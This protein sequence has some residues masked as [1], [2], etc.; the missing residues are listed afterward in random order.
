MGLGGTDH[1]LPP[2]GPDAPAEEAEALDALLRRLDTVAVPDAAG[3]RIEAKMLRAA[4]AHARAALD[5]WPRHRQPSWYTGEVAFGLISLLLPSAPTG[6]ADALADRLAAIPGF[7]T[8]APAHLAGRRIPRDWSERARKE[9]AALGRFFAR[10]LPRHPLWREDWRPLLARAEAALARFAAGLFDLPDGSPGC[11]RDYLAFLM[12]E[13]HGLPW[14]PEEAVALAEDAFAR[15][16]DRLATEARRIDPSRS[17][18]E[19]LQGLSTL[20]PTLDTVPETYRRWHERTL[21]DAGDLVTPATGYGL[22][23]RLHAEWARPVIGDLYFLAYRSPPALAAGDGSVYWIP[24]P[25]ADTAAYL[26]GQ[27]TVAIKQTHAVHHGSIGHHTQNARAREAP[28][29]LARLAGTDCASGIAFLSAGTMVEGWACYATELMAEVD[30]FYTPA[31]RLALIQADRRNA[32]SVLADIR[33]HTGRWSLEEMRAFYR[34]EAGFP[35]AR[36]WGETTRNSLLPGTRLMY[37]LGTEQIKALRREVG[38]A[39]KPLFDALLGHG[40][41]PVAW[42]AEEI[43]RSRAQAGDRLSR[44]TTSAA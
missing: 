2:S 17:W 44:R 32:A 29:R 19:Q 30:G 9:V 43:R 41:V 21:A 39:P 11:G 6:A 20:H 13:V 36:V 37:F 26:R 34:D 18:Q 27:A 16:G 3:P 4:M 31:E 38:G 7:L 28:S 14:S 22:D 40:H 35:A 10:G 1:R 23:F 12:R 8:G 15:L 25:G 33:L 42:A 24:A 5:H